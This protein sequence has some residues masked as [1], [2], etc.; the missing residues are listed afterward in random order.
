MRPRR[1]VGCVLARMRADTYILLTYLSLAIV[2]GAEKNESIFV[3]THE[4]QTVKKG[5][6]PARLRHTTWDYFTPTTGSS[7]RVTPR[8]SNPPSSG[9]LS[10]YAAKIRL[11]R[12]RPR[13][14]VRSTA[15]FSAIVRTSHNSPRAKNSADAVRSQTERS[16]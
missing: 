3:A 7:F 2:G 4:W 13:G 10:R 15:R 12:H 6:F 5:E 1:P 16:Q 14:R 9:V 11:S 8:Q